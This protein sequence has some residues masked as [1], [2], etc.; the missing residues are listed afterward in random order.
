MINGFLSGSSVLLETK[1]RRIELALYCLPRALESL[2]NLAVLK[3][4][5]RR[6][7][8]GEVML[9]MISMGALMTVYQ[10]EPDV[11]PSSYEGILLRFFGVN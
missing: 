4:Y 7:P 6:I 8:F 3:G 10:H 5:C 1:G 2:W 11:I 9:F